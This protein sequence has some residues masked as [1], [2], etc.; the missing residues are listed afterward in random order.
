MLS[1]VLIPFAFFQSAKLTA[2]PFQCKTSNAI[3]FQHYLVKCYDKWRQR[4]LR[5]PQNAFC[6]LFLVTLIGQVKN[7]VEDDVK[8]QTC[9]GAEIN[10]SF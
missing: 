7:T 9:T 4:T 3:I 1:L 2:R 5:A 8:F 10:E 6:N